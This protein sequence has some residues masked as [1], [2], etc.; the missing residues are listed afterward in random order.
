MENRP[1]Q[2]PQSVPCFHTLVRIRNTCV[3]QHCVR[4][5]GNNTQ[6]RLKP[7]NT[8]KLKI[9]AE[10]LLWQLPSV[11]NAEWFVVFDTNENTRFHVK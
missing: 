6:I 5:E 3:R 9:V 4:I 8:N 1:P 2:Q 11:M 7:I 10:L